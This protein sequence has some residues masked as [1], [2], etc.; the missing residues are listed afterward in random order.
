MLTFLMLRPVFGSFLLGIFVLYLFSIIEDKKTFLIFSFLIVGIIETTRFVFFTSLK[1]S[2]VFSMLSEVLSL[3]LLFLFL[4][5][6]FKNELRKE[7]YK[8]LK[9]ASLLMKRGFSFNSAYE[10][11]LARCPDRVRSA[12]RKRYDLVVFLQQEKDHEDNSLS[13]PFLRDLR[14]IIRSKSR[15][16]DVLQSATM[17][18]ERSYSF[19]RLSQKATYQARIQSLLLFFI[20]LGL[21]VYYSTQYSNFLVSKVWLS[22][23]FLF[24][25]GI[26][27]S[28]LITKG[29]K[30]KV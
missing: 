6:R 7:E 20:F 14:A 21:S 5:I 8:S 24:F 2:F 22:S 17:R 13:S 27:V 1:Y 25:V 10:K 4:K 16:M 19:R 30:W 23:F 26:I 12:L 3:L 18:L 15:P 9:R 28:L 29:F 11:S